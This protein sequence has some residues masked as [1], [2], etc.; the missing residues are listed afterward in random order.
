MQRLQK[1]MKYARCT[2]RSTALAVTK[3]IVQIFFLRSQS[4]AD[5]TL[6]FVQVEHGSCLLGKGGID[7]EEA[8]GDVCWCPIRNKKF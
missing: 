4:A 8:F 6:G 2:C 5:M 1:L 7:L 3:L